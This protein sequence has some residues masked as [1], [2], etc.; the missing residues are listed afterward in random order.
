M[1]VS[2]RP[3]LGDGVGRAVGFVGDDEGSPGLD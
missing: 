1:V 3:A 2:G